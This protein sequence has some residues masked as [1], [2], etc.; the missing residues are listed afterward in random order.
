MKYQKEME[1][2]Y[3]VDVFVAGGGAAGVAA[4]V[5]AARC[6]AKV[7]LAEREGC[8]GGVGTSGL[9]PSF[10]PFD[11]GV[12]FLATGIGR[13]IRMAVSSETPIDAYW[14]PINTEE[15]KR[16]YD[17]LLTESGAEFRFFTQLCDVICVDGRVDAVVLCSKNEMFAVEAKVYIDCTGDGTLC[18][19]AGNTVDIGDENG[20]VM[21]ST[22]CSLWANIDP[23]KATDIGEQNAYIEQAYRD[24]VLSNCD[25]HLPGM[26]VKNCGVGGGNIGHL[27]DM[28]PLNDASVT[29]AMVQGR[30]SIA[31]YENYFK[32]YL[33]G[34]EAMFLCATGSIPGVRES[35]R[36]RC[37]YTLCVEDF[38]KR[39]SFEDEIGRYCYPVDVHASDASQKA[40]D[41]YFKEYENFRYQAGESYGIPY[42][43]LI[44][45]DLQN[46]LVAGRCMGTDR[47]MQSSVRVMPGCFI[48]GQAAG[49]AAALAME[50]G[51]VR[52]VDIQK[53]QEE[54]RKADKR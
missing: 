23:E 31:E 12:Q 44:P 33:S 51:A 32:Q 30:K 9:V 29:C 53:L 20:N 18:A 50:T 35:R 38:L 26:F 16:E 28:N 11:D 46:V 1:V 47:K 37:D 25:K 45:V 54:I 2:K 14:T 19:L 5:S 7:F 40:Y 41:E 22:L 39:A 21:A 13:E 10:A 49:I 24:G 3:R 36:I 17:A 42:R 48:T 15:L 27:F 43:S 34:F 6:G 8:F 4:A 52:K